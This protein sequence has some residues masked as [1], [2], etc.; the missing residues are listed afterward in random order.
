VSR[1]AVVVNPTKVT[2]LADFRPTV[3]AAMTA[4]GWTSWLML[5][6]HVLLRRDTARVFR[7]TATDLT[8][9]ADSEQPWEVDGEIAGTTSDLV[10]AL[11][12][13]KLRLRVPADAG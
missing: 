8:I 11:H 13:D 10:I 3:T 7:G 2:E 12:G 9:H 4:Q 5:A 1:A 6:F